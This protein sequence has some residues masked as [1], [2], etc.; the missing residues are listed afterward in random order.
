MLTRRELFI[1]ALAAFTTLTAVAI[2]QNAGK[3]MMQSVTLDWEKLDVAPMKYGGRRAVFQAR[4][5]TMD[6]LECHVT[7]L[8]PGERAHA[9]HRHPE[10][11]MIIVK[12]GTVES[13]Q[14]GQ[15]TRVG[16]GSVIFEASG[17]LHGVKNVGDTAASYYVIKFFPPGMKYKSQ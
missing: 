9:P 15:T 17:E 10:E 8:N 11:E 6:E 7:T 14:N 16:P 1:A 13:T 2:A 12:D 5:A 4:T 3:P